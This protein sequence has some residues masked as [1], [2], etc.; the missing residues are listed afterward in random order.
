MNLYGI[1]DLH[2]SGNPVPF[3]NM[4]V[5]GKQYTN[6]MKRIENG[7]KDLPPESIVLVAG[8]IS[9]AINR[10]EALIDLQWLNSFG[11]K[12]ILSIGNHDFWWGNKGASFMSNWVLD[13]G[14]D[15][16][17]FVDHQK[18]FMV[19]EKGFTIAAV[20]GAERIYQHETEFDPKLLPGGHKP[21]SEDALPRHW[22]KYKRRLETALALKPDILVSHIPPFDEGGVPNEM[23]EM[24]NKSDV[25][26][27]LF[28]HR[29]SASTNEYDNGY[30]NGKI[31]RNLLCERCDF[32]PIW[33]GVSDGDGNKKLG[34]I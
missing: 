24:I 12:I 28:G 32:K 8:D 14:L 33:L 20:K 30:V 3:K 19:G 17:Y 9:W 21:K 34:G 15:N 2:L 25:K 27:I 29:H 16:I 11:Q 1:S 23:T 5:F 6:Y 7:F 4:E 10:D 26:M 18:L 31:W 22:E 13:N